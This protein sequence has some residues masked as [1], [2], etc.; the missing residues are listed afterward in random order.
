MESLKATK[1][2][3]NYLGKYVTDRVE[4]SAAVDQYRQK[5]QQNTPA[6][7]QGT[8]V[9][10]EARAGTVLLDQEQGAS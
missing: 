1:T 5:M 6:A 7:L 2:Q 3:R 10:S 9:K 8:L 4:A